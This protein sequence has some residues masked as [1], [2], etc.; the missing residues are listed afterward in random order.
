MS[1]RELNKKQES[2]LT[3]V[4]QGCHDVLTE[5]DT[6]LDKYQSLGASPQSIRARSQKAWNKIRWDQGEITELRS[7]IIL[8]TTILE[9]LN[10]SLTRST[11]QPEIM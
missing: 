9:A 5:L 3:A 11:S 2:D 7:R 8:N 4:T 10:A 6:M 1:K